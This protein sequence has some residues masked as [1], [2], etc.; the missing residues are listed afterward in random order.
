MEEEERQAVRDKCEKRQWQ[1]MGFEQFL[2]CK[3]K[4]Q[5]HCRQLFSPHFF[6]FLQH[7]HNH[8]RLSTPLNCTLI[9]DIH[10]WYPM[11]SLRL[12]PQCFAFTSYQTE[13]SG[14]RLRMLYTCTYQCFPVSEHGV[15]RFSERALIGLVVSSSW[16]AT[17]K[18]ANL[19]QVSRA[20]T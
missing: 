18:L 8:H 1:H 2:D 12:A 7:V 10:C 6:T 19:A 9:L 3:Q 15:A 4:Y 5:T 17:G 14:A 20:K 11:Y 13:G 16:Q